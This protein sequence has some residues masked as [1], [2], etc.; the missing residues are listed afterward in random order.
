MI[1]YRP[2]M[3]LHTYVLHSDS[4]TSIW[5]HIYNYTEIAGFDTCLVGIRKANSPFSFAWRW[6]EDSIGNPPVGEEQYLCYACYQ[7]RRSRCCTPGS[8]KI[9]QWWFQRCFLFFC[10]LARGND[11]NFF[12]I[13][14]TTKKRGVLFFERNL[15]PESFPP[16]WT[17][18]L[19]RHLLEP[20]YMD[21]QVGGSISP[22]EI[23]KSNERNPVCLGCIQDFTTQLYRD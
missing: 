21:L 19:F 23:G 15:P 7:T 9:L 13:Y 1:A 17:P 8:Q 6:R 14:S 11:P 3:W 5:C 18:G 16:K 12:Y 20:T 10:P 2:V 22:C 4:E